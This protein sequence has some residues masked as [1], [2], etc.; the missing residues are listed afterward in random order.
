MQLIFWFQRYEHH[1][2]DERIRYLSTLFNFS[3]GDDQHRRS[4][5]NIVQ[6]AKILFPL[7]HVDWA[8]VRCCFDVWLNDSYS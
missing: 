2:V 7:G 3:L 5:C 4:I 1:V 6:E 8:E